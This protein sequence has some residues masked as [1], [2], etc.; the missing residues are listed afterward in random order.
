MRLITVALERVREASSLN[1][2][3]MGSHM[4]SKIGAFSPLCSWDFDRGLI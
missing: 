4:S 3:W 2:R 1:A